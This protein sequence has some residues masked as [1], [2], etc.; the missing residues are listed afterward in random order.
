MSRSCRPSRR[1]VTAPEAPT[2]TLWPLAMRH[3]P[4]PP[5]PASATCSVPSRSRA[6]PR[7]LSSEVITGS[8]GRPGFSDFP[9]RASDHAIV[10]KEAGFHGFT[11]DRSCVRE[12]AGEL[13]AQDEAES[14]RDSE[15]QTTCF[16]SC[17]RV[18][19]HAEHRL[20]GRNGEAEYAPFSGPERAQRVDRRRRRR[21]H[22]SCAVA[23]PC[24]DALRHLV[25][26][27]VDLGEDGSSNPNPRGVSDEIEPVESSQN[28]QRARIGTDDDHAPSLPRVADVLGDVG[29]VPVM[30]AEMPAAA[31]VEKL[32]AAHLTELRRATRRDQSTLHESRESAKPEIVLQLLGRTAKDGREFIGKVDR[33]L[34]DRILSRPRRLESAAGR[35]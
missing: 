21:I 11:N 3:G 23:Y 15:P 25:D 28:D 33:D 2:L 13:R 22:D 19:E 12:P 14:A 24:V 1:R 26:L 32:P 9:E 20:S 18:I 10:Q 35:P 7:G 4:V 29:V 34:H 30:D 8:H 31:P 16:S 5:L 27:V 6:R 17:R